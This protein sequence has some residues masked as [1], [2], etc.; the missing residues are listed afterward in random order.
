MVQYTP[1][2]D[3]AQDFDKLD[4]ITNDPDEC[5]PE[6]DFQANPCEIQLTGTGAPPIADL[7]VV[8]QDNDTCPEGRLK[9]E[10]SFNADSVNLRFCETAV[11]ATRGRSVLFQNKGN[12]PLRMVGF[13]LLPN[14]AGEEAFVLQNP[15]EDPLIIEP[16]ESEM[17]TLLYS[18][19]AAGDHG[20]RLL[21][22]TND[23]GFPAPD[24][25][26]SVFGSGRSTEPEIDVNP[27]N[28]SFDGVVQG[29]S[30][31][32]NITVSNVGTGTLEITGLEISGGSLDGEFSLDS[33]DPFTLAANESK[34]I[35]VTYQPADAG[36]DSGSVTIIS[37]DA[38]ESQV[39]VTLGADV[40][41]DLEVT[42]PGNI[43]FDATSGG[44]ERQTVTLQNIGVADLNITAIVFKHGTAHFSLHDL[45]AD[46]PVNPIVLAPQASVQ[47]AVEVTDTPAILEAD[48]IDISHDSP[49]D[50]NPYPITLINNTE[51]NRPPIAMVD[52]TVHDQTGYAQVVLDGSGRFD[53]DDGDRVAVW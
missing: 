24:H 40:R 15:T 26:Y 36:L 45:P 9:C 31:T 39:I 33:T 35:L 2:T 28:I 51:V 46:F 18:P 10:I 5:A 6:I 17:L 3:D 49:S 1:A 4:V 19:E 23:S 29:G 50:P 53:F 43:E 34:V 20:A 21:L 48:Q 7:E 22:A 30:A 38:D 32:E 12:I 41:P 27:T 37:N 47:F 44:T 52:P 11:G 16:V 25:T 13:N 8:C 42:P 14:P